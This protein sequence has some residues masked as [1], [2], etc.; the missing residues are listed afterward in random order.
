LPQDPV[1][2]L[3]LLAA[4]SAQPCGAQTRNE[5]QKQQQAREAQHGDQNQQ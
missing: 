5:K 3:L 4:K 2:Q 1:T